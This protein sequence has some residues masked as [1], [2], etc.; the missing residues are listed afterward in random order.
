MV[1]IINIKFFIKKIFLMEKEE[2]NQPKKETACLFYNFIVNNNVTPL[3]NEIKARKSK[4]KNMCDKM[5]SEAEKFYLSQQDHYM[6]S[7]LKYYKLF[8]SK[9]MSP[10]LNKPIKKKRNIKK[11]QLNEKIYFG[12][13]FNQNC[14][15]DGLENVRKYDRIKKLLSKSPYFSFVKDPNTI[16]FSKLPKDLYLSK[17]DSNKIKDL[18][19]VHNYSIDDKKQLRNIPLIRTSYSNFYSSDEE[20]YEEK[21]RKKIYDV[22]KKDKIRLF[23]NSNKKDGKNFTY[24]LLKKVDSNSNSS[25]SILSPLTQNNSINF[26]QKNMKTEENQTSSNVS[27]IKNFDKKN[28]SYSNLIKNDKYIYTNIESK[29]NSTSNIY[30]NTYNQN[31]SS[32]Q[33][34]IIF[35]KIREKLNRIIKYRTPKKDI[36]DLSQSSKIK[37]RTKIK[38]IDKLIKERSEFKL[39]PQSIINLLREKKNK[40]NKKTNRNQFY[41]KIKNQ[42]RLLSIVDNLKNVHQNAPL[43]LMK[44]LND[45]YYE[46]SKEMIVD[47]VI[48]KR[49]N[50]IYRSSTEGKIIKEK[51][52]VKNNYINRMI[53]KNKIDGVKLRN[54][55][56]KC[57]QLVEEIKDENDLTKNYKMLTYNIKNKN[58]KKNS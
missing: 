14:Q 56:E 15:F 24:K 13:F 30:N 26:S 48:T 27:K 51:M 52:D 39:E 4:L 12:T 20:D 45:D 36:K 3:S 50:K 34:E 19:S 18:I 23:N 28:K 37:C 41:Y 9:Y 40:G 22:K 17:E 49:I 33:R 21:L 54:K 16:K 10:T 35:S 29:N 2:E 58:Y 6:K 57:D 53:S 46:K 32:A 55:Y 38:K 25:C 43:N 1:K 8:W 7:N 11:S 47:D 5:N 44:R 42:I 31:F